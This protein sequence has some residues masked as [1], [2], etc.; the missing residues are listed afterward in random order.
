MNLSLKMLLVT[1]ALTLAASGS[2]AETTPVTIDNFVRAA[3]DIEFRKYLVN[4]GGINKLFHVR[5]PTP[6]D[7][8]PT[9]RMNRDTLYSMAVVDISEGAVLTVPETG[10][11]YVSVQVVNQDH[12]VN[13]VFLGGGTYDLKVDQFDTPYVVL[14]FR[15]LV[16][17][18]DPDDIAKVTALQDG[19]KLQANSARPFDDPH[20][21]KIA[22][23]EVLSAVLE[24]ARFAPDSA[25][26]FGSKD[27]VDPVRHLLG[28]GFGWGG[29]PEEQAF[30]LNVEPGLALGAYKIEV[31]AKVPVGA[32]W[33]VS[34][35]NA[36]GFF[37][38]NNLGVYV[39]NS[40]TGEV[41]TDGSMT[42]HFGACED[43]RVNCLPI[44]EGWNYAVRLYQPAPEVID[45][46]WTFPEI[47]V[48]K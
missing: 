2:V 45:G 36:A 18:E 13:E 21:D 25:G 1:S 9:I 48:A 26:T 7:M 14:L 32:F 40:V 4:S 16:D 43:G 33:S 22:F 12:Y 10:D 11:R 34:L 3:T 39:I 6:L 17:S 35:Y 41:N 8:Q 15:Y 44:M 27:A 31:P 23:D 47:T 5:E 29:L 30:Y 24:L 46:T 42:V 37:E 19:V 20:Y 28:T 38:E